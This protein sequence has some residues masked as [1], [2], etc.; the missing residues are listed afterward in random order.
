[1]AT[2]AARR[3]TVLR[4]SWR[5]QVHE[6]QLYQIDYTFFINIRQSQFC[7]KKRNPIRKSTKTNGC[8]RMLSRI[9]SPGSGRHGRR[10]VSRI[11]LEDLRIRAEEKRDNAGKPARI[12]SQDC[13]T[14]RPL[15]N[16]QYATSAAILDTGHSSHRKASAISWDITSESFKRVSEIRLKAGRIHERR[17]LFLLYIDYGKMC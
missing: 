16:S 2:P 12:C 17:M 9:P 6:N 13:L 4:G 1:M 15:D 3:L 14:P 11:Q 8:F 7:V 5:L 10:Q